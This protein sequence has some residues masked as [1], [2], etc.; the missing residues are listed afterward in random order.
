MFKPFY[1]C[2]LFDLDGTVLD[3]VNDITDAINVTM[4]EFGFP[5]HTRSEV[6]SYL[7]DGARM[8]IKR[9]V[10]EDIRNDSALVEKI[11]SRYME[12]YT[13][14][15]PGNSVIYDGIPEL[16]SELCALGVSLG[17]VTNKPDVQTQIMIPHY[18]GNVFSFIEGNSEKAPPKPDGIR[19]ETALSFL[20]K[21]KSETVFVGDSHVD[22]MTAKNSGVASIGVTWGFS[23]EKSFEKCRP[24]TLAHTAADILETV[25]HGIRS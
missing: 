4:S 2:V 11:L 10:P 6:R 12:N 25:K 21:Q 1:S 5:H 8:L 23:G 16:L 14:V 19:V 15:C 9:A 3:T 7:N 13:A 17:I 18:F 24:D 20:G 22:V